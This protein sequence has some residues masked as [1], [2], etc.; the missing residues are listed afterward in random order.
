MK[1]YVSV[2]RAVRRLCPQI[3]NQAESK[4][5]P[6][7][8][9]ILW[10]ELTC[11]I[12]GSQV[13]NEVAQAATEALFEICAPW[14]P[15]THPYIQRQAHSVLQRPMRV[16]GKLVKYRFPESRSRYFA[17]AAMNVAACEGSL[18]NFIERHDDPRRLRESLVDLVPGVGYK[19]ASMFLRNIGLTYR[20][21]ILDAHVL[22]FMDLVGLVGRLGIKSL[23]RNMY[24]DREKALGEY[25]K[26]VGY[27]LGV[28]DFAIWVVMR[29]AKAEGYV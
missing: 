10:R 24:L 7:N 23:S 20:L 27:E 22:D 5:T 3:E 12:L 6:K 14:L 17:D 1:S 26:N 25:A 15:E 21:A 28:V 11:C 29:T 16:D 13:K 9:E 18:L 2:E 8:E 19:Q 4:I